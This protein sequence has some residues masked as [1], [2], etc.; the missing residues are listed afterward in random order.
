MLG[1]SVV[2]K[3]IQPWLS[4]PRMNFSPINLALLLDLI[5]VEF[6]SPI[7]NNIVERREWRELIKANEDLMLKSYYNSINNFFTRGSHSTDNL[8]RDFSYGK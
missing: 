3:K 7:T 4:I 6:K 8:F 2:D 5:F 1:A